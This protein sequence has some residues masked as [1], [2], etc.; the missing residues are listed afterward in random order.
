MSIT[1]DKILK[2]PL[3][4]K[5][6][7]DDI[8]TSN[9]PAS[10]K[11][12]YGDGSWQEPPGAS[13][14]GISG[15]GTANYIPKW[16]DTTTLGNSVF[17]ED[18]KKVGL[19]TISPTA[20]LTLKSET[21]QTYNIQ[22]WQNS[23][24]STTV[25]VN[26]SGRLVPNL[27]VDTNLSIGSDSCSNL[28]TG[29]YNTAIGDYSLKSISSNSGNIAIGYEAL[30]NS[31]SDYNLAIG[32]RAGASLTSR[33]YLVALG[34]KSLE[35]NTSGSGNVA[36]GYKSLN[37]NVIGSYNVA[38][39]TYSLMNNTSNY[40]V[41]IGYQSLYSNTSGN[42]NTAIGYASLNR[43]T[44]GYENMGIGFYSLTNNLSG[45]YNTSIGGY[46]LYSNTSGNYNIAIGQSALTSNTVGN[47]NMAI[48]YSSLIYNVN[49]EYNTAIGNN[50]MIMNNSGWNNT[51]IGYQSLYSNTSGSGNVAIGYNAG[52][53][54]TGS[55]KLY[56]E[57]SDSSNPLIYGDFYTNYV[58]IN[59]S[60]YSTGSIGI[61]TTS[62]NSKLQVTGSL[63]L[64]YVAKTANYT[65]TLNDF[66]I[67]VTCSSANITI[68]LP[69]SVGITGRIYV[70]KKMDNTS[71]S[72]IV[73]ANG[74]QTIDGSETVSLTTQY[75][76]IRLQSNGSNWILI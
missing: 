11:V 68:T 27:G 62:P 21:S 63:S 19:G 48:G 28:T 75:Q 76:T 24:G 49:G 57:N 54:E 72:V 7:V 38:I 2:K 26:S 3:L 9:A 40:N 69:T 60:F 45:T 52:F 46:S 36:I 35:N 23:S 22:E 66:T 8:D 34:A 1:I 37:L 70:I 20:S 15:S 67:A 31:T 71:Y 47:Y 32:Y 51:A 33:S 53:Y 14:G 13:S 30:K 50:A 61:G 4:H 18:N 12:L 16:T 29:T 5:H 43:N 73:D 39:G 74:T 56:I 42:Y 59:G 25:F 64:P 55:D 58:K 17:Y 44:T 10:N 41:A 6:K 65:A